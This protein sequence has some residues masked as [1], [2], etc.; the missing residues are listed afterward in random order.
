MSD[1]P[2]DNGGG[3][4]KGEYH[5]YPTKAQM[6][7]KKMGPVKK[8]FAISLL[9]LVGSCSVVMEVPQLVW[10]TI[11][12]YTYEVEIESK[13]TVDGNPVELRG[14]AECQWDQ[15]LKGP[16]VY[17]H[18]G[19]RRRGGVLAA[20]LPDGGSVVVLH[21]VWCERRDPWPWPAPRNFWTKKELKEP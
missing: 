8:F 20:R 2:E 12:P 17:D 11:I 14:V 10:Y 15:R 21:T 4:G 18:T 6:R 9:L 16:G 7:R 13:L 5:L 19:F 1:R 3:D